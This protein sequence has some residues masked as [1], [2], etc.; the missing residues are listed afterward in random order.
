MFGASPH[1]AQRRWQQGALGVALTT[2][3]AAAIA[4]SAWAWQTDQALRAVLAERA[5]LDRRD[6]SPQVA[7]LVPVRTF[8]D[9]LPS[10]APVT[11][12]LARIQTSSLRS[13]A[14]WSGFAAVDRAG[15]ARQFGRSE[16]RLTLRGSYPQIR[17]VLAD[18]SSGP[19]APVLR[20][21][22]VRRIGSPAELEAQV[23]WWLPTRAGP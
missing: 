23:E 21:F 19:P 17:E 13:G 12:L 14:Q 10:A 5:A 22:A 16:V 15:D 8:A 20:R 18:V 3:A 9:A 2:A 4:L 11:H 1:P 6:R 7:P